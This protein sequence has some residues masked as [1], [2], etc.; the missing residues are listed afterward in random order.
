MNGALDQRV[1]DHILELLA[2]AEEEH[3]GEL[4]ERPAERPWGTRCGPRA[5]ASCDREGGD[6]ER[7]PPA[8]A[9]VAES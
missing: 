3:W 7:D 4:D 8:R 2:Q 5:P 1:I 6:C 9:W